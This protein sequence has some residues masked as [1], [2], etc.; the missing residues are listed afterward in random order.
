MVY[1]V[2]DIFQK[3]LVQRV[4][5]DMFIV[6]HADCGLSIHLKFP[7]ELGKRSVSIN[8]ALQSV[9]SDPLESL[10]RFSTVIII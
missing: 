8:Q 1:L 5:N 4:Q 9:V 7:N 10:D 6:T 2:S 3:T